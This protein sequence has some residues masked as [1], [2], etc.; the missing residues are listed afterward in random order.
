[1]LMF[2]LELQRRSITNDW[3]VTSIAA[4]PG[5][6][7]TQIILNGPG[8]GKPGLRE[9]IMQ[10]GFS[11][12]GQSAAAGALPELYAALDPGARPGGY[13]GPCCL[14]ETRG[15]VTPSKI[16]PQARNEAD[17][18]RLWDMSETLTGV[19]FP[20]PRTA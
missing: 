8:A 5:W 19:S 9:R 20:L 15:R 2:G 7:A 10:A 4:H 17:C 11:A 18:A 6:S 16:M 13:Y 14:M 12:L 3:G 1:M